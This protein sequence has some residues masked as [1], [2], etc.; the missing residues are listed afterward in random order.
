MRDINESRSLDNR[1]IPPDNI[2]ETRRAHTAL[3]A[4]EI[5]ESCGLYAGRITPDDVHKPRS[6][7]IPRISADMIGEARY[8]HAGRIPQD[9]I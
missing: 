8:F 7:H 9:H 5:Q 2:P 1:R 3:A 6:L 4:D